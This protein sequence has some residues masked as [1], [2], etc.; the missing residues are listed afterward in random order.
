MA[1]SDFLKEPSV[2]TEK[3]THTLMTRPSELDSS[4]LLDHLVI[5]DMTQIST[6]PYLHPG[7]ATT[8]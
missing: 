1:K 4:P 6:R 7:H 5:N 8:L 2:M 3:R